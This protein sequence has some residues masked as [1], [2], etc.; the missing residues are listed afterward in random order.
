[1][2]PIQG[3]WIGDRLSPMEKIS[4]KSF[5]TYGA[6]YHLYCFNS[7]EGIPEGTVIKDAN[8]IIPKSFIDYKNFKYPGSFS[9][10]F[11]YKLLLEKGGWW[12]DLDTVA[13]RQF[14]FSQ[15]HVIMSEDGD[16]NGNAWRICCGVIKA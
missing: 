14:T 9:N 4:I 7:I 12:A 16:R 3:L 8:E 11:R 10:I 6:P 13:L 15:D 1:M 5:L 2:D